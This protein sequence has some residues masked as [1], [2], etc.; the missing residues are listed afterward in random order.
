MAFG[1]AGSSRIRSVIL[2]AINHINTTLYSKG[3]KF[4]SFQKNVV[5]KPRLHY[6]TSGLHVERGHALESENLIQDVHTLF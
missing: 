6:D 1:A 3:L 4:N 2:Q 5:D